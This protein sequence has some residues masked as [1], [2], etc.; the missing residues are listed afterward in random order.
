MDE[1][2]RPEM[3]EDSYSQ[4]A[5]SVA[6]IKEF[7]RKVILRTSAA[8][9]SGRIVIN[10]AGGAAAVT[11]EAVARLIR[12]L[13]ARYL[14][15]WFT[16]ANNPRCTL[17]EFSNYGYT[18][19]SDAKYTGKQMLEDNTQRKVLESAMQKQRQFL[20]LRLGQLLQ[21]PNASIVRD[22][23]KQK[24][25]YLNLAWVDQYCRRYLDYIDLIFLRK[26]IM[27]RTQNKERYEPLG[28][29]CRQYRDGLQQI[30]GLY[31]KI[32]TS[33]GKYRVARCREYVASCML[34]DWLE[35]GLNFHRSCRIAAHLTRAYPHQQEPNKEALE[36]FWYPFESQ[37]GMK[38]NIKGYCKEGV[39]QI[40]YPWDLLNYE[41][42]IA[43]V[44]AEPS[45]ETEQK[46]VEILVLREKY[47]QMWNLLNVAYPPE[48]QLQWTDTLYLEAARFFHDEYF[49]IE[50]FAAMEFPEVESI[51]YPL[52][53][54]QTRR[55]RRV[56]ENDFYQN[57]EKVFLNILDMD[58]SALKFARQHFQA[59]QQ[60]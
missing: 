53:E 26:E 14:R 2:K 11:P 48:K 22:P 31:P 5:H 18:H 24:Y 27:C 7:L 32:E 54:G 44:Y 19:P 23:G 47:L 55:R 52:E 1:S 12:A 56:L 6:E 38:V 35:G 51:F 59:A 25:D 49:V 9:D 3:I 50:Y 10:A 45:P 36:C 34:V 30:C 39:P 4:T 41:E 16:N 58:D 29:A 43:C 20:D 60:K 8:D 17:Y 33:G 57:L 46:C 15:Q 13:V 37:N 21:D 28:D 42:E 40:S